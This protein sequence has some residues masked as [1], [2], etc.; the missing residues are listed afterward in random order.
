M[1]AGMRCSR[2]GMGKREQKDRGTNQE[3]DQ[4]NA[5]SV[6]RY[7]WRRVL[8]AQRAVQDRL[9]GNGSWVIK[10]EAVLGSSVELVTEGDKQLCAPRRVCKPPWRS[11]EGRQVPM[12]TEMVVE[13]RSKPMLSNSVWGS[14]YIFYWL[15]FL[16]LPFCTVFPAAAALLG[17]FMLPAC[18]L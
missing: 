15:H 16:L 2:C 12:I 3:T 9:V 8:A 10:G 17:T 13:P 14:L 7:F 11:G 4:I 5:S 18:S 6:K 1:N